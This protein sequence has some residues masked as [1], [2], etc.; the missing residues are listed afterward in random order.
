MDL[1]TSPTRPA[2]AKAGLPPPI[3]GPD[4]D[5]E[6]DLFWDKYKL[7]IVG[8]V[9]LVVVALVG[10]EVYYLVHGSSV[11]AATAQLDAAKSV[12]DYQKVIDDHA[13]SLA[14]ANAYLLMAGLQAEKS[15]FAGAEKSFRAFAEK[16]PKHPLAPNALMGAAATLESRGLLDQARATYQDA[17]ARY[18]NSYTA[19]IALLAEATVLKMQRKVAD[20]S[21]VY[22]NLIAT[23][24]KSDSSQEATQELRRIRSLPPAGAAPAPALPAPAE[25]ITAPVAGDPTPAAA[26]PSPAAAVAPEAL[27]VPSAAPTPTVVPAP[28]S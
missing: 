10:F 5:L 11:K 27:P 4:L 28:G 7:P 3:T 24:P 8:L 25:P 12:A 6:G 13:G 16:F 26:S 9:A 17:A 15:D 23:Y 14:A 19:P 21:H 2:P 1:N 22:E 20:A 18:Q